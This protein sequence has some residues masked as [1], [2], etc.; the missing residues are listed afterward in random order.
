MAMFRIDGGMDPSTAQMLFDQGNLGFA[1][2]WVALAGMLSAGS[3]VALQ[4]GALPRWHAWFGA[5]VAAALL[6]ARI[7]W[8]AP[9]FLIF[10]PYT[11]FW[12]WLIVTSTRLFRDAGNPIAVQPSPGLS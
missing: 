7:F 2:M 12:L 11:L 9:T 4:Y 10:M 6:V 1:T 3:V 8:A 5:G